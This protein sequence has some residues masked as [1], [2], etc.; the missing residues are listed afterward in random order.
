MSSFTNEQIKEL[1]TIFNIKRAEETL[2]VR[3]GVVTKST[4]VW[5]RG[6]R[7][8]DQVM[9]GDDWENIKKY[10][11]V[12]QLEKPLIIRIKYSESATAE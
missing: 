3:D 4:M 5:W 12:Y 7:E 10:P 1:E 6:D 9:A 11:R 8:L 2:P